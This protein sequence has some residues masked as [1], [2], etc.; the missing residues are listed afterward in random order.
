MRCLERRRT[1]TVHIEKV[2]RRL[3]MLFP[4]WKSFRFLMRF[5]QKPVTPSFNKY[6]HARLVLRGAIRG[7]S[8][9]PIWDHPK[10]KPNL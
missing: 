4:N 3:T 1:A 7:Q 8:G 6:L 9:P 5:V 2:V 10:Q